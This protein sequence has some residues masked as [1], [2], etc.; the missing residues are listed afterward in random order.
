MG[1]NESNDEW[2]RSENK[3]KKKKKK[4]RKVWLIGT[5]RVAARELHVPSL[6]KAASAWTRIAAS[7]NFKSYYLEQKASVETMTMSQQ[8]VWGMKN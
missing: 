8:P 2:V 5:S 3:K 1:N 7:W 6:T 4:K